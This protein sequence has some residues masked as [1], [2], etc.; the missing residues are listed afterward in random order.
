M[1]PSAPLVFHVT[2]EAGRWCVWLAGGPPSAAHFVR[3]EDAV[4]VAIRHAEAAPPSRLLVHAPDG[5][6]ELSKEFGQPQDPSDS[7]E[8]FIGPG[9]VT[10]EVL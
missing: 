1:A 10:R 7:S 6:L 5:T 9:G 4:R 3:K 2:F 8:Y